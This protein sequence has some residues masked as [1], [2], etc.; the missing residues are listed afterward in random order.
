MSCY[1]YRSVCYILGEFC[2]ELLTELLIAFTGYHRQDIDIKDSITQYILILTFPILIYT[3]TH[4]TTYF[5]T[6]LYLVAGILQ[7]ANLEYIR[8]IPT[9]FQ[10]RV[11]EYETHRFFKTQ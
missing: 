10:G 3:K 1:Q 4:T 6:F 8:I 9:F 7:C 2:L 5:L 11:R